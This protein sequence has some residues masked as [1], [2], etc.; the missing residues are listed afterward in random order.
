MQRSDGADAQR[1]NLHDRWYHSSSWSLS[2]EVNDLTVFPDPLNDL[3]ATTIRVHSGCQCAT[4]YING[5]DYGFSVHRPEF[6]DVVYRLFDRLRKLDRVKIIKKQ[7]I[8]GTNLPD[9]FLLLHFIIASGE[10]LMAHVEEI[11]PRSRD[12]QL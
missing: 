6:K 1:Q 12:S 7:H 9:P 2:A 3:G 10:C 4:R 8:D 11:S 5:C